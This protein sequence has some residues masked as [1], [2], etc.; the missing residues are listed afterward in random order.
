MSSPSEGTS[1]PRTP[2]AEAAPSS[3]VSG[4]AFRTP[5]SVD[6]LTAP[7]TRESSNTSPKHIIKSLIGASPMAAAAV[8]CVSLG[9]SC[10]LLI[11]VYQR[12]C[13]GDG[14]FLAGFWGFGCYLHALPL[15]RASTA[16]ICQLSRGLHWRRVQRQ[17]ALLCFAAP[18]RR[19]PE[20]SRVN[21]DFPSQSAADSAQVDAAAAQGTRASAES[22]PSDTHQ[23][24]LQG[25]MLLCCT[26]GG[27]Q[28]TK[29]PNN[30]RHQMEASLGA[31]RS[32]LSAP[33][34]SLAPAWLPVPPERH[35]PHLHSPPGQK[36]AV[37]A[38]PPAYR[39]CTSMLGAVWEREHPL[40][41]PLHPLPTWPCHPLHSTLCAGK[42]WPLGNPPHPP[43]HNKLNA[44]RAKAAS[45]PASTGASTALGPVG[46]AQ[47]P[48][49]A[50]SCLLT[51]CT[52]PVQ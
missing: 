35:K 41:L 39:H 1:P 26:S 43:P 22:S 51:P 4:A 11:A 23:V 44:R 50:Q 16:L 15:P 25:L 28:H 29:A 52:S 45:T 21:L 19:W 24:R 34:W 13:E 42:P 30:H 3:A 5:V 38:V 8:S 36:L 10:V 48:W 17:R 14:A 31:L 27:Y 37:A 18:G 9:V 46:T 20:H 33:D 49:A 7:N 2:A 40:V 12:V 47:I 32:P 6:S